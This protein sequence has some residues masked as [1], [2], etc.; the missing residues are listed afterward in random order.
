MTVRN[1]AEARVSKNGDVVEF[2]LVASAFLRHQVRNTV[3]QLV[4]VGLGKCSVEEFAGLIDSGRLGVAGPAASPKG[5]SL[6]EVTYASVLP[7]AA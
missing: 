2:W 3:G 4:R 7:F 5:L 6:V 1:V